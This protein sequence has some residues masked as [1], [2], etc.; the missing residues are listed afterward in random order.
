MS[1][2]KQKHRFN[3]V[4]ALIIL[5]ILAV[6]AAGIFVFS[7][8]VRSQKAGSF[9]I[10]Y[11]IELRT[12]RDELADNITVGTKI[13]DSAKKYQ[14]GEVIAVN[15][16]PAKFTGTDLINGELVYYDYPEHS[17]VSLT[18][19]TTARLDSEGMYIVDSG[20]R[21]SVGTSIYVRTPD[22]VGTGYCTKFKKTE[23]R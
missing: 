21:L 1:T 10:E 11:V 4:D 16:T 13:I 2:T 15:V 18:V 20:Y 22:Y 23:V 19:K 3:A 5:L 8:K 7:K 6:I 12:V 17:D 9:D 14:L